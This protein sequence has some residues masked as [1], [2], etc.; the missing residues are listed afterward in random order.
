MHACVCV[1]VHTYVLTYM[2]ACLPADMCTY[3]FDT[4]TH[5]Y[6][7]TYIHSTHARAR[8]HTHTQA[9]LPR[10]VARLQ[11]DEL[12]AATP[13][14]SNLARI[15][16][17]PT[18]VT[19]D[20]GTSAIPIQGL[21]LETNRTRHA[22]FGSAFAPHG[23]PLQPSAL[24]LVS[25]RRR[26]TC[27]AIAELTIP[28]LPLGVTRQTG[29]VATNRLAIASTAEVALSQRVVLRLAVGDKRGTRHMRRR[30]KCLGWPVG[31]R[32]V[33]RRLLKGITHCRIDIWL[34]QALLLAGCHDV[35]LRTATPAH[36]RTRAARVAPG[37]H[38][39]HPVHPGFHV[40]F[41]CRLR[42][43]RRGLL[44][45]VVHGRQLLRDARAAAI[46]EP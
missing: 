3:I 43:L 24:L 12:P 28:P 36:R 30:I 20:A 22:I 23:G 13:C 11:F 9:H 4:H 26:V 17:H 45:L 29:P 1:C 46:P 27:A 14:L 41:L 42:L 37:A 21:D 25:K 39:R 44:C 8:A 16:I 32:R 34:Q 40:C 19:G 2:H 15:R 38:G 18:L 35:H 6:I 5:T 31:I 10:L 7:H 33:N